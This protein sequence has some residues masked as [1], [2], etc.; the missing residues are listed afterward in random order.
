VSPAEPDDEAYA[1][2]LLE[3]LAELEV[4]YG[5]LLSDELAARGVSERATTSLLL[6]R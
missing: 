5:L 3:L 1:R 4:A 6:D 2:A